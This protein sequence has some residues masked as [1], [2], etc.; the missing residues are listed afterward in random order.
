MKPK[1]LMILGG[2]TALFLVLA[3][4]SQRGGG[5][6][7][8]EGARGGRLLPDLSG[9]VN[10]VAKVE[11]SAGG[12]VTTL[13]RAGDTWTCAETNG[14]G[15]DFEKVKDLLVT[16]AQL[17]VVEAKTKRPENHAKLELDGD[18]AKQVT[19]RDGAGAELAAVV[20]GKTEYAR[21]GQRIYARLQD[22]PQSYLCKG[23]LTISGD[24]MNWVKKEILRV[25][26][27]RPSGVDVRHADGEVLSVTKSFPAAPN[28]DVAGVPEDR[29]LTSEAA[30]NA[31]GTAL[32]YLSFDDV[33]PADELALAENEAGV[34]TYRTFDGLILD[35]RTSKIDEEHWI[36]LNARFEPPPDVVGPM[37]DDPEGE[38][39]A[40]PSVEPE[41]QEEVRAE[42]EEINT[43]HAGWAYQVPQFKANVLLR[44][45]EDLLAPLPEPEAEAEPDAGDDPAPTIELPS[46][47][48][49]SGEATE[50]PAPEA[51]VEEPTEEPSEEPGEQPAQAPAG[52]DGR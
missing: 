42:V 27:S 38:A 50:E 34:T 6:D 8:A 5:S 46:V 47:P 41:R 14:Y 40:Q 26:S 12:Q 32:S 43:R 24:P 28:W 11:I 35:V 3:M 21:S 31:V 7:A 16:L 51:P 37:P 22:D 29:A 13:E 48:T 9:S 18:S 49:E 44:R 30:G 15:A 33:R 19:L 10:D 52:G 1:S 4:L 23:D 45:M 20:L 39:E 2:V 25:E 36:T 17:E